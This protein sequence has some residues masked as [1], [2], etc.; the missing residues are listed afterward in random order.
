[1][2]TS[3]SPRLVVD[4]S[5]LSAVAFVEPAGE[6]VAA[7]L[8]GATLYATTL[9]PYELAN[10]ARNK[11]IRHHL[12]VA[13]MGLALSRALEVEVELMEVALPAVFTLAVETGLTAYDASYLWLAGRLGAPLVTLDGALAEAARARGLLGM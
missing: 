7:R 6:A 11:I 2:T 13:V 5:A 1:V 9:L 8:T 12:D 4:A 3:T 10:T